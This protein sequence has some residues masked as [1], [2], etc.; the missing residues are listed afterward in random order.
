MREGAIRSE[1]GLDTGCLYSRLGGVR[2]VF[3]RLWPFARP[4]VLPPI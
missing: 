3:A 4:S 1:A 2:R